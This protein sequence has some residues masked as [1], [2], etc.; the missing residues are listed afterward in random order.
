MEVVIGHILPEQ[1]SC[2]YRGVGEG[3][4]LVMDWPIFGCGSNILRFLISILA[5]FPRS[6]SK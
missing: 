2:E 3:E 5:T 4:D 6:C 1:N